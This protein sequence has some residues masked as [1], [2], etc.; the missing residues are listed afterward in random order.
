MLS[1]YY[2][3]HRNQPVWNDKGVEPIMSK[4]Y[5]RVKDV[6]YKNI[7]QILKKEQNISITTHKSF[8]SYEDSEFTKKSRYS[9]MLNELNSEENESAL[10]LDICDK[11]GKALKKVKPEQFKGIYY[12]GE[13][14]FEDFLKRQKKRKETAKRKEDIRKNNFDFK[15]IKFNQNL[16]T[17]DDEL[18][19]KEIKFGSNHSLHPRN[20]LK[21]KQ[22]SI[23]KTTAN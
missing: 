6:D 7:K 4:Y 12:S 17:K 19:M 2:K 18:A 1:E 15:K 14:K 3:F 20:L 9:T 10:L 22:L 16:K 23:E 13:K 5:S 11:I 8:S 21:Y